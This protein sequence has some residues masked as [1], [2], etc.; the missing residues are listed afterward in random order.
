MGDPGLFTPESVTWQMHADPMMWVAGVIALYLQ[1][2][3]PR[4]V[5]GVMQNSERRR[6]GAQN[7]R[8]AALLSPY[9]P[10]GP[11]SRRTSRRCAPTSRP[12]PRHAPANPP[13]STVSCVPPA[14]CCAA[15]PHICA[16]DSR[17]NTFRGPWR[18]PALARARHRTNSDDSSPYWTSQGRA[19]DHSDGGERG[20][21]GTAG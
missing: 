8:R 4:A 14:S 7:P 5:R 9:P 10:T 17:P 18:G 2:R 13:S 16:G 15:F 6:P 20:R 3:H 11:I 19:G 21:W 1:A 12:E